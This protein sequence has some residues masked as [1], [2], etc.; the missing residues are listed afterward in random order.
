[1]SE[2]ER[3]I[4]AIN[5]KARAAGMNYGMCVFRAR[6]EELQRAVAEFRARERRRKK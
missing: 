5:I 6:Q 3:A 4:I 1:M 2:S